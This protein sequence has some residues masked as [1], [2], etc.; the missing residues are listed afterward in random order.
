[1]LAHTVASRHARAGTTEPAFFGIADDEDTRQAAITAWSLF[2]ESKGLARPL[3]QDAHRES[4]ATKQESFGSAA[5]QDQLRRRL[6]PR[7]VSQQ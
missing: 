7:A 3:V 5:H 6:A 1:M 4:A 2:Y